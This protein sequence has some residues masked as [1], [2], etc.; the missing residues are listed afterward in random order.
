MTTLRLY[1]SDP[2]LRLL[3]FLQILPQAAIMSDSWSLSDARTPSYFI[4]STSSSLVFPCPFLFIEPYLFI[5]PRSKPSLLLV[6]NCR[7]L[8][9]VHRDLKQRN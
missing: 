9:I 7:F 8:Y 5:E 3:S 1:F 4:T 6:D 2:S